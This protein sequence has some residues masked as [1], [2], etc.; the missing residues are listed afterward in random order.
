MLYDAYT[1]GDK[2]D[3]YPPDRT[4]E[5]WRPL[6]SKFLPLPEG[7]EIA[8]P[9]SPFSKVALPEMVYNPQYWCFWLYDW[10]DKEEM[11]AKKKKN[12]RSVLQTCC[13]CKNEV[14][15][16]MQELDSRGSNL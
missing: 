4:L 12:N 8:P 1:N 15:T 5:Y 7:V 3:E 13:S 16:K 6:H 10:N 9:E 2:R 11:D 14:Y